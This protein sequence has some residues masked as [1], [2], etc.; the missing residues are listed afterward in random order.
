MTE[1]RRWDGPPEEA[2]SRAWSPSQAAL[3][4]E[5]LAAP[6]AVAGGWALDLWLGGQ[7]RDH[8][9]LEIAVPSVF[10]SEIQSRLERLGLKLFDIV[11][12]QA[13]A[14]KPG[15]TPRRGMHQTWVMDPN[16]DGWIMD[17]FREPGDAGTWVYRR[18]EELSARRVWAT[19]RTHD[20]IPYVAPQIVLLF[21]AR[22]RRDK[23]EADFSMAAP[24]LPSDARGWLANALRAAHPGH[25]WIDRLTG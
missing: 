19:G 4:L 3:A 23:D 9:D 21:K 12:G 11:D 22:A 10:F 1:P 7:S 20:G 18:A 13:I 8:E 15:E 5:G 17:I 2:W 6:W 14:L 24:R 25:S 16:V